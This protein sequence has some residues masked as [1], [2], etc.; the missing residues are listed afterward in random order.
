M[1]TIG[2][3]DELYNAVIDG[4]KELIIDY[5]IKYTGM[6]KDNHETNVSVNFYA[7]TGVFGYLKYDIN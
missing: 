4:S 6:L 1:I 2:I 7:K 3:P 5:S